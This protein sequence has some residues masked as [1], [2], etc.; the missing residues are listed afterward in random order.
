MMARGQTPRGATGM[1]SFVSA[2][3]LVKELRERGFQITE[4]VESL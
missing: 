2:G 1:E 3:P 4:R